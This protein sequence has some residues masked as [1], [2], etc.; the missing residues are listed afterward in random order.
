MHKIREEHLH[1]LFELQNVILNLEK[2]LADTAVPSY[3]TETP[4]DMVV[5]EEFR[6]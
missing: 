1:Q 2:I 6:V 4:K 5:L 3:K